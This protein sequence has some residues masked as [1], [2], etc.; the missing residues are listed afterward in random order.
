MIELLDSQDEGMK[1]KAAIDTLNRYDGKPKDKVELTGA[2]G[3][4]LLWTVEIVRPKDID[5]EDSAS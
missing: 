5:G 3:K 1:H 2:E 4:E